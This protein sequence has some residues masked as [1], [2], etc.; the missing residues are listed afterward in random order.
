MTPTLVLLS[1][2]P[3]YTP[4]PLNISTIESV[5]Y[6]ILSENRDYECFAVLLRDIKK[7]L[8][9]QKRSESEDNVAQELLTL[10]RR[11]CEIVG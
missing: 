1:A 3:K 9:V 6:G 5:L 7:T 2:D 10:P 8:V 11:L 4:K